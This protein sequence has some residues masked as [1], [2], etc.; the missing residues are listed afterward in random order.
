MPSTDA[1]ARAITSTVSPSSRNG[2]TPCVRA[3]AY[4]TRGA[5]PGVDAVPE[6]TLDSG[7]AIVIGTAR[8]LYCGLSAGA[9]LGVGAGD[10]GKPDGGA[11][12]DAFGNRGSSGTVASGQNARSA[13]RR[14]CCSP[15]R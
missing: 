2:K 8:T 7:I 3:N 15:I 10:D 9:A 1:S 4:E 12:G 14:R 6:A 11:L 13:G 5:A